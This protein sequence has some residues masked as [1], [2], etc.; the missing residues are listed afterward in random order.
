MNR[1]VLL[2]YAALGIL[3]Y[4]VFLLATAPASWMARLLATTSHGTLLVE[5][6]RGGLWSGEARL[7]LAPPG[8]APVRAGRISWD[9][10]GLWLVAG[11]I[12]A[13]LQLSGGGAEGVMVAAVAPHGFFLRDLDVRFAADGI[14]TFLPAAG[15]LGPQGTLRVRA[16]ALDLGTSGVD[17]NAEVV[18][19]N[20][21]LRPAGPTVLGDYRLD[22][23]GRGK[24]LALRL[25]TLRGVL[26]ASGQGEWR[27][28]TGALDFNGSLKP[29][30]RTP[31]LDALLPLLG[32]DRGNGE[33]RLHYNGPTPFA[34]R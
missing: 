26:E 33:R 3:L 20:A 30:T 5:Q 25:E 34:L 6:P 8:V 18:W 7:V 27:T 10:R 23:S 22:L 17:G 19:E 13:R 9:I 31:Q 21:M 11:Q 1:R 12:R 32:E 24:T 28:E 15:L 4:A 16:A 29:Q 14:S 2:P